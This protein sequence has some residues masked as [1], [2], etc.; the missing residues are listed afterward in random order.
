MRIVWCALAAFLFFAEPASAKKADRIPNETISQIKDA[1]I[2]ESS[3]LATSV[4]HDDLV[5]TI[6]DRGSDAAIYAV[7]PSNGEVVGV[8][9]VSALKVEDTESI[10]VDA[11]GVLWLGD[12]GD[13]DHVRQNVS[14][15]SFPEP[16]PSDHT[17]TSAD[18]YKVSFPD[19]PVD[20]EGMLVHPDTSRIHLVSKIRDGSGTVFELPELSP[21]ATAKARDL[22]V[23]A[24]TAVTDAT[25]TSG[26]TH[27][28]LRTND[29]IWVYDP[30]TWELK[31]QQETPKV[32]QGESI[33][34]ERDNRTVLIGSEG[35][36]SPIVR[37]PVP[38]EQAGS[39]STPGA[40]PAAA[41][42]SPE[43]V[44]TVIGLVALLGVLTVLYRRRVRETHFHPGW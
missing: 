27:A 6:N 23:Q 12:L 32:R 38:T 3:G 31:V 22:Q 8:T 34:V 20:V 24:P 42:N 17:I 13:N 2:K 18:R 33:A 19:G 1:R 36:N 35:K 7:R 9:D 44:A 5:Y 28:L 41:K 25:Y 4:K 14:I 10:A 40:N 43:S 39:A 26:G 30:A 37:I 21:G 15:I 29:E 16:G 11:K